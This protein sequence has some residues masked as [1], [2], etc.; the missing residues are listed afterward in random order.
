MVPST[1]TLDNGLTVG[2]TLAVVLHH[3]HR[4]NFLFLFLYLVLIL[5]SVFVLNLV[6]PPGISLFGYD[7]KGERK[8]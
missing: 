6:P 1:W 2:F 4:V 5:V 8:T 3:D 7:K